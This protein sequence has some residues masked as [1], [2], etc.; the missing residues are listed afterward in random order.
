MLR[1]KIRNGSLKTRAVQHK[2]NGIYDMFIGPS[3][4]NG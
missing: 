3:S 1:Q 4:K 2:E